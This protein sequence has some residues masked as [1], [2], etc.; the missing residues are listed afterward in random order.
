MES[1]FDMSYLI[2][3]FA[4]SIFLAIPVLIDELQASG[5]QVWHSRWALLI[6]GLLGIALLATLLFLLSFHKKFRS[7]RTGF[8][9]GFLSRCRFCQNIA[10]F[11]FVLTIFTHAWLFT[12]SPYRDLVQ[13]FWFKATTLVLISSLFTLL[14]KSIWPRLDTRLIFLANLVLQSVVLKTASL[15]TRVS[16]TPFVLTWE[17]NYRLY[18][19]SLLAAE[20]LYGMK[21]PLSPIDFSLNLLNGIPF[22]LGDFPIWAHRL[23]YVL[24]TIGTTLLTAWSLARRLHLSNNLH[25][26]LLIGLA[27]LYLLMEG[28]VKYNLQVAVILVLLTVHPRYP[29][30]SLVGVLLASFWAG[31]SRV[32]WLPVPAMLAISLYILEESISHT[33]IK[34]YL[35]FPA[36]LTI[37]GLG[38]ALAG[39]W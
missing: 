38:S 16:P 39:S 3:L 33:N 11:A 8:V 32:N 14:F 21:V 27:W 18:Y 36:L 25:R 12:F 4:V 30:R 29:W 31:L 6:Y 17:E 1:K 2:L 10:I 24:L 7:K 35:S 22:L 13:L 23:W 34:K 9:E 5:V 20:R 26:W 19:A 37:I 28:G 15:L